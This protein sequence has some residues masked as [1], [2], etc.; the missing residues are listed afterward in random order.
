MRTKRTLIL[1][2]TFLLVMSTAA[3]AVSARGDDQAILTHVTDTYGLLSQSEKDTLEQQAA[4]IS[5]VY[6][7]SLYILVVKDFTEYSDSTF[8]FAMDVFDNYKLG[9][10]SERTGVLLMLSMAERDYELLFHGSLT[11][12][13]FTEYGR[14]KMEDRFLNY[15]R[16]ND[17]YG[18]FREYLSCSAEYLQAAADGHPVDKEKSFP[19]FAFIPGLLAA[20]GVSGGMTASMHSEGTKKDARGYMVPGSVQLNLRTD[21]FT[22]RTVTRTPR[23]TSSTRSSSGGSSHHSGGY[24]GRS[25]KF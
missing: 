19:F 13:A 9:W 10:G 25:G 3:L 18:G 11:D 16:D 14:D 24:S 21:Q 4:D 15:F 7:C 2:L 23:Q 8:Q 6:G 22:H 12:T 17:F 5:E 1:L 20:L